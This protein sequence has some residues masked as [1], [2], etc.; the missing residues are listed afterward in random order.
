MTVKTGVM[1]A[2]I[3]LFHHVNNLN[4]AYNKTEENLSDTKQMFVLICMWS[5]QM[6]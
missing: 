1:E 4:N 2:K 3:Q 6:Q 5:K